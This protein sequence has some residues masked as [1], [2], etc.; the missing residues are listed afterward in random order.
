MHLQNYRL[1]S[2]QHASSWRSELFPARQITISRRS[3][4]GTQS[5][6]FNKCRKVFPRESPLLAD[7]L[8]GLKVLYSADAGRYFPGSHHFSPIYSRDSKSCIQQTPEGIS[9]GVT[10]SR[11]STLGTQSPVF[12]RRRKVFPKESNDRTI[13]LTTHKYGAK[14]TNVRISAVMPL[15]KFMAW[16]SRRRYCTVMTSRVKIKATTSL[17][18]FERSLGLS[19]TVEPLCCNITVIMRVQ[20]ETQHG[21]GLCVSFY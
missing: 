18:I 14:I 21:S 5:P 2:R 6:V 15:Y 19:L 3:T 20:R 11:P 1:L 4:L 17:H 10:I 7:L 12:S 9:Q 8:S 16:R 13:N